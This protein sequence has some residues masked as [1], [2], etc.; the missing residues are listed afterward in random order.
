MSFTVHPAQ[1]VDGILD[2]ARRGDLDLVLVALA[3]GS[4]PAT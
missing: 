3:M 4:T 2:L 1:D